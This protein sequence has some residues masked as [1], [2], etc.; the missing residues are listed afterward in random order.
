MMAFV[1]VSSGIVTARP[2]RPQSNN[3]FVQEIE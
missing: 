2:L 3:I 1:T